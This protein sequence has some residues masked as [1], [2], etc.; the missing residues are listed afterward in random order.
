MNG[1]RRGKQPE[2]FERHVQLE[3]ADGRARIVAQ[4]A[5]APSKGLF[6][7]SVEYPAANFSEKSGS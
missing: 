4:A 1:Q 2:R 7:T 3:I 5:T 6:L